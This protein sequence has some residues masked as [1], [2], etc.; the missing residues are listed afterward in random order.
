MK[1]K[2]IYGKN[3]FYTTEG[4]NLVDRLNEDVEK[5]VRKYAEEG[6]HLREFQ[7]MLGSQVSSAVSWILLQNIHVRRKAKR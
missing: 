7:A 2:R 5:L 3:G 4:S 1:T 6:W